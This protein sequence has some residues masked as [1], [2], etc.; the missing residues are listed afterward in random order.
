[1]FGILKISSYHKELFGGMLLF[2]FFV[3]LLWGV[4]FLYL[5]YYGFDLSTF[6][7]A[8]LAMFLL[9]L[10][11]GY[12]FVS[13][14]LDTKHH[15][16]NH[17]LYVVD[18]II[19]ELNLPLSTIRANATMLEKNTTDEKSIKRLKRIGEATV[20]F[21]RLHKTLVYE[22]A[23]EVMPIKSE[24]F[25]LDETIQDIIGAFL[26]QGR[27]T[28]EFDFEPTEV[29]LDK[30][31][32][33]QMVENVIGNALKYSLK[34][35]LVYVALKNNKLEV[36]DEGIGMDET[37]VLHMFERYYQG[38]ISAEGMG[39]G[40]A[41]VKRFCDKEGLEMSVFSVKHK[42]TRVVIDFSSRAI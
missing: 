40:L 2:V 39:I 34:D 20:R 1:L 30:I 21:E 3:F 12:L 5:Y 29:L 9:A 7:L 11:L 16:Q 37:E 42:G 25:S 38:D 10:G 27:N 28:I 13:Y 24:Q 32:C 17:L 15:M 22:I 33:M 36:I 4:I 18:E 26:E 23:K 31:G 19:H 8:L 41:L 35:S 6:L 14:L